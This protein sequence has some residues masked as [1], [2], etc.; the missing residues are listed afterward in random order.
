MLK[1]LL[2]TVALACALVASA[3]NT[4]PGKPVKAEKAEKPY[5]AEISVVV[6]CDSG[7]D[8]G[9]H[10]I[11][12]TGDI[13]EGD[14]DRFKEEVEKNKIIRAVVVLASG[15]GEMW[16]GLAIGRMVK[17]KSFVT[18]VPKD[19]FCLSV[20]ANIW[21]AGSTRYLQQGSRVGFHGAFKMAVDKNGGI[22]KGAKPV[23]SSGGNAVVGAYLAS[24]GFS[25]EAI[26]KLTAASPDSLL[27]LDS[28]SL[29]KEL[30]IAV[31]TLPV[32]EPPKQETTAPPT[33]A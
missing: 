18:F 16:N 11:Y 23:V 13:G 9:C 25:D 33:R 24:L 20:C 26:Y 2:A 6:G 29:A 12:V 5:K 30:G 32:I 28:P 31:E 21:L 7:K 22:L 1:K 15:G 8:M 14:A 10:T 27:W 17:E 4:A 3:A 19:K